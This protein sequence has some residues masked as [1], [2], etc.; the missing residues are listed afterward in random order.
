METIYYAS[1]S[2]SS[3]I[4]MERG[5]YERYDGSPF[6][7]G[8]FQFDLWKEEGRFD[9]TKLYPQR[10]NWTDLKAKVKKQGMANSLLTA[11]MPTAS[12]SQILGNNECF[13]P[14]TSN[15]YTRRTIAGDFIVI[16]KYLVRDLMNLGLWNVTMKNTIIL[17]S[18]YI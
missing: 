10:M 6:S 8:I 11:L 3:D 7:N 1:I 12:T 9:Y 18:L 16:N 17:C 2:T 14:I 13:E 15:M 5:S 4:A